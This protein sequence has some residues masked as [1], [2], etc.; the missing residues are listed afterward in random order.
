MCILVGYVYF[1]YPVAIAVVSRLRRSQVPRFPDDPP[2]VSLIFCVH[3]ELPQL[4]AKLENCL[5]ID[6]PEDRLEI[7]AASD[8]STDGSSERLREYESRGVLR[9]LIQE[10]RTGKTSLLNRTVDASR[11]EVLLFTDASTL[12]R[13]DAVRN[14]VRHYSDQATG[15]VGGELDFVNR[16][17]AAVS[18]GHGLYWRYESWIRRSES[19]LGSLAYVPGANYSMRRELWKPVPVE[20]ADDC[21]SPLNV[22]AAGRHVLYDADAVASEVASETPQGLFARRVRM[23]TRDIEATLKYSFL[24]N[25]LKYGFLS[26]SILSHKLLRWLVPVALLLILLLNLFLLG[27]ALFLFTLLIQGT[28]YSLAIAGAMSRGRPRTPLLAIPLYFCVSNLGALRGLINVILRR[29]IGI[30]QP[31]G[32]K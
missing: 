30:W 23:A 12:L 24:L 11:G 3:N 9:A 28:F 29:R 22:V 4:R 17:T 5:A 26:I 1:L 21:V 25:P 8:G 19:R 18:S 7:L 10:S 31:V 27:Q 2:F 6:Y 14:H 32:T 20:F 15:C 16:Q 13:P